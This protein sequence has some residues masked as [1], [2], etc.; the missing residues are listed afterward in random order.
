[1]F[2]FLLQGFSDRHTWVKNF[3]YEDSPLIFDENYKRKASYYSLRDAIATMCIG[4]KIGGGVLLG[5]DHED[6]GKCWGHEWIPSPIESEIDDC[7][8]DSRPDWLQN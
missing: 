8:G 6:D 3:Y 7:V 5:R 2:F 4:G 1:M